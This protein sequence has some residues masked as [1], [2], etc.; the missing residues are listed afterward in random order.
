M[1][2]SVENGVAT[3]VRGDP[4][5]PTTAGVLCAKVAR[6]TERTYHAER[7]LH[8]MRRVGAKGEG[9]FE[10]ISW[11]EALDAI[12]MRL[13]N[14]A[15]REP[16]AILPY[17]YAGTMGLVQGESMP[18]RFFHKLGASRLDRTICASAGAAGIGYTLGGKVGMD[19][20]QFQ[21]AQV[22]LIWGGNPIAS[23]VHFWMRAQ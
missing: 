2:V 5:H 7:L 11:D 4:D 8:P 10:R 14:I 23:N 12:A 22:I 1:L 20:E 21:D 16:Q 9:R 6:Y 19:V 17:N 15:A 3:K 13:K 18:A